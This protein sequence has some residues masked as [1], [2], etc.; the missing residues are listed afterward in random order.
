MAA[1]GTGTGTGTGVS[2][3]PSLLTSWTSLSKQLGQEPN[4]DTHTQEI[5]QEAATRAVHKLIGKYTK[6]NEE[7]QHTSA[8]GGAQSQSQSQTQTHGILQSRTKS[9]QGGNIAVS[10]AFAHEH[11]HDT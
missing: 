8:L 1:T 4:E 3:P 2:V 7:R 10:I 9:S 11:S 5:Y 6:T